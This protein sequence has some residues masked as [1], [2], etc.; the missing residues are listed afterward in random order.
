MNYFSNQYGRSSIAITATIFDCSKVGDSFF[1][2]L[3][4]LNLALHPSHLYSLQCVVV[5]LSGLDT[6]RPFAPDCLCIII[7]VFDTIF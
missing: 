7:D 1:N 6:R 2:S 3:S 4:F 5:V